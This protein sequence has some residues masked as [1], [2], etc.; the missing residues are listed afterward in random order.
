MPN[1]E[2]MSNK[3]E[4]LTERFE[5]RLT[6]S[7]RERLERINRANGASSISHALR[8]GAKLYCDVW[9]DVYKILG[10]QKRIAAER[11]ARRGCGNQ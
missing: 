10:N 7:T 11:I 6:K 3:E 4:K 1:S 9:E 2:N 8:E 5:I